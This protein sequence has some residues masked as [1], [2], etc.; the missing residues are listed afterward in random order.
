M[1]ISSR[2]QNSNGKISVEFQTG[3]RTHFI[4]VPA[5]SSGFGSDVNGGEF[6]FLAMAACYCNDLYREAAKRNIEIK[7]VEVEV[8]GEFGADGEPARNVSYNAKVSARA[9]KDEILELMKHTDQVAEI[10]NTIRSAIN[11]RLDN[12]EAVQ[13]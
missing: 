11:V 12:I 8:K 10:Q 2:M 3:N 4:N 1:D 7:D 5:K 9:S 13:L 6:L